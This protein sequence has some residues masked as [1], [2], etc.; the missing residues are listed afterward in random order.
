MDTRWTDP[1]RACA[2]DFEETGT[3]RLILGKIQRRL[4][5]ASI[6]NTGAKASQRKPRAPFAITREEWISLTRSSAVAA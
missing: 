5:N 6:L 4:D 2:L 3:P 1:Q